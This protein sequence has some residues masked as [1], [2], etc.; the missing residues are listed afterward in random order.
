MRLYRL[1]VV[2]DG[3]DNTP[4]QHSI[5]EEHWLLRIRKEFL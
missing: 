1:A 2:R 4:T 5:V 3:A